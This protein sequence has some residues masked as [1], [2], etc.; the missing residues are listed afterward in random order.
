[1]LPSSKKKPTQPLNRDKRRAAVQIDMDDFDFAARSLIT[2]LRCYRCT[3]KSWE[4]ASF[5][6][7]L[8]R[9]TDCDQCCKHD[10]ELDIWTIKL[11]A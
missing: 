3:S 4:T 2:D 11:D 10:Y 8:L 7:Y 6:V 9:Y 5:D 1:M